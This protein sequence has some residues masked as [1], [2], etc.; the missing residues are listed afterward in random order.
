[1]NYSLN[2]KRGDTVTVLTGDDAGKTGTIDHVFPKLGR[3]IVNGVNVI[4]R[5]VKKSAKNPAG[6]IITSLAPVDAS[7]VMLIC[8]NCKKPT[9]LTIKHIDGSRLRICKNCSQTIDKRKTS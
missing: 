2:I 7:N 1:M 9:R 3:V 5:H 4:K 8:P 6:G